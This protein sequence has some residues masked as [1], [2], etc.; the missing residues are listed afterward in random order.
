MDRTIARPMDLI[1][2]SERCWRQEAVVGWFF[3]PTMIQHERSSSS[4]S[5]VTCRFA[6][7][8]QHL[9][10]GILQLQAENLK[11]RVADKTQG[12]LTLLHDLGELQDMNKE[13]G[14]VVAVTTT[15]TEDPTMVNNGN[16]TN[17]H[18]CGSSNNNKNQT[19]AVV[20]YVLM[21]PV[22]LRDR[23]SMVDTLVKNLERQN[24][25]TPGVAYCVGGQVCVE[26]SHRGQGLLRAMYQHHRRQLCRCYSSLVT[27]VSTAN[28]TS[29]R[30]HQKIGF[31]I[32]ATFD[33]P[34]DTWHALLW[35]WNTE[36]VE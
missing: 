18:S 20:G 2:S 3:K 6:A 16:G 29:L 32:L 4:S 14:Q 34:E 26:R 23:I 1:H 15:T 31:R 27:A 28:P 30:A 24:L 19:E 36:N 7:G 21:M 11:G 13:I 35:E 5:S 22:S 8:E 9:L 12:F 25:M 17:K 33:D 10:K